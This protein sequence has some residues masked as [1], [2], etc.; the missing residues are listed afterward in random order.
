MS[1]YTQITRHPQ[2]GMYELATW[3]DD[4]FGPHIYG[5]EFPSDKK[6]YSVDLVEQAQIHNL[7]KDDVVAAYRWFLKTVSLGHGVDNTEELLLEFLNQIDH[8]Y[9]LR[10]EADPIT[11]NGATESS[12]VVKKK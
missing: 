12:R 7:W 5:V 4:H 11:G 8:Q 3:H 2:T 6:V 1:T 10:W 9:K